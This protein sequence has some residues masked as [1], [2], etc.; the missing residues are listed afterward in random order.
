MDITMLHDAEITEN[1]AQLAREQGEELSTYGFELW[2]CWGDWLDYDN[3]TFSNAADW[4]A[5][6]VLDGVRLMV[7]FDWWNDPD[8]PMNGKML[9]RVNNARALGLKIHLVIDWWNVADGPGTY[10][11]RAVWP[12]NG[13]IAENVHEMLDF[14]GDPHILEVCNEP[15]H[16]ANQP[17]WLST[18]QYAEYVDEYV[19]GMADYGSDAILCATQ[20]EDGND[21]PS[22]WEWHVNWDRCIEGRHTA[23]LHNYRTYQ[24]MYDALHPPE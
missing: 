5:Q 8:H 13:T 10:H 6:N 11:Q 16:S 22:G 18:A 17:R 21:V 19:A 23:V 24:A 1:E 14:F 12:T 7:K 20:T 4:Y 9:M 15:Y 2:E 3:M